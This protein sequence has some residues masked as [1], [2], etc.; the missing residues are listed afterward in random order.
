MDYEAYE[1]QNFK[2]KTWRLT[3]SEYGDVIWEVWENHEGNQF[4]PYDLPSCT[5]RDRNSGAILSMEWTNENGRRHR[6]N[7]PSVIKYGESPQMLWHRDGKVTHIA[8]P[9]EIERDP[10]TGQVLRCVFDSS[11]QPYP[12]ASQ[13]AAPPVCFEP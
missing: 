12:G 5:I 2:V 8:H 7:G 4:R 3:S 6:E 1:E 10:E 11:P 9:V 13:S